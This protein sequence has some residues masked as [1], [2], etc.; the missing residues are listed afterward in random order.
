MVEVAWLKHDH[1][2]DEV[3]MSKSENPDLS[4]TKVVWGQ[5]DYILYDKLCWIEVLI[6]SKSKYECIAHISQQ[7]K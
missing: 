1:V 4:L 7:G 3:E 6:C 5:S 2:L